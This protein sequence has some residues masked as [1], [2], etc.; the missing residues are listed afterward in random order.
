MDVQTVP[1][2]TRVGL[3]HEGRV[4]FVIVGDVLDQT[5]EQHGVIARLDRIG[6][7]VQVHFELRRGAFFDDGVGR[8]AL[9]LRTFEDV[10]QAVD[11][12]VEVIDQVNLVEC[13]RLPEI[14]ERGGCGRPFTF[15]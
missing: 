1:C 11:V 7:V 15:S 2:L 14:G 3:G 5:L 4:H 6:N 12:F 10:L 13:G 9:L 8:N